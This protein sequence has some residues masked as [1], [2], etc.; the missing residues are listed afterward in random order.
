M[1][2]GME[3]KSKKCRWGIWGCTFKSGK[4]SQSKRGKYHNRM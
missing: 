4:A 3:K 1:I 2:R